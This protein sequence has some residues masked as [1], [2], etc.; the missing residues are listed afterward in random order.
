M[1]VP[2]RAAS[3]ASLFTGNFNRATSATAV[4]CYYGRI[5]MRRKLQWLSFLTSV[6]VLLL[7][8]RG[9]LSSQPSAPQVAPREELTRNGGF[10]ESGTSVPQSWFRDSART[11]KKGTV[12]QDHTRF[13]SG[14]ASLK[15]EPNKR[16]GGDFPLAIAQVI[17]AATW[18]GKKVEFSA[19]VAAEGGATAVLGMLNFVRQQPSNLITV[20]QA[21][22]VAGWVRQSQIYEVP[23]DPSVQ[24]VITCFVTGTSGSAWFDDVSVVPYGEGGGRGPA[25]GAANAT[26]APV[27]NSS[28]ALKASVEVDVGSVIRQIP[29]TLYG[30]NAEWIWNGNLLWLEESRRAHPEVERLTQELG[31]SLIRYPGGH[32][33]DFYHWRDGVGPFE[34]RPEALHEKGRNDRSRPNFGTDEALEFAQHVN[35]ELLITVNAGSGSAQEAADWVAHV[36]GK[37]ERVRYWEVGNELYLN[38]GS[39]MS[40]SITVNPMRYAERFREFAQAMQ[41][42]DPR[43]KLLAIGGENQGRY[44]NVNYADWNR[45]VLEKAGDQIDFLAVHNAYAPVLLSGDDKDL[46]TVYAAML[47]APVLI[48]RNLETIEQQIARYAPTRA[49]RIGLAVT[50]WGPLFQ[51]DFRGRYVDHPKTLG[52]A[53]FVAST[54]KAFIESPKMEI[55]NFFLLNDVSVLG[56]IGSRDGRVPPVP[57]WAP[58][59]RYFAFQL[60]TRHFGEQLV[61]SKAVGPTYDSKAVGQI[62]AVK[63]VPYLDIVSSLSSDGR[64]LYIM[65]INKHFDSA[66]DAEIVLRG[67]QPALG[68]TAWTLTGTGIDAHTGT[69]ALQGLLRGKGMEDSQNPRFSK[70]GA[71]EV[72]LSS[73]GVAGIKAQF[74][75]RFPP[76]S[77]TSLVLSRAK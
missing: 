54:L 47:A 18:A 64:K 7:V 28:G 46:R 59:A 35:G 11:G 60:F 52:S 36:N 70:G 55:A 65:A 42:V 21:S 50:E 14:N 26:Q 43:I 62:E 49:A 71:G 67:F 76:H 41:T 34:A 48:K 5:P 19:Y 2:F 53:L 27:S 69:T 13:H 10:E 39:A 22:G 38:E 25:E 15:L 16:N 68:G 56:F 75:Y 73:S 77:V 66:I 4:I 58:T 74:S 6:I 12:L 45:T 31:V 61:G 24:L 33:S 29:R 32:Y 40:K 37:S 3:K 1:G 57:D 72:I 9:L 30:A 44:A 8:G 17:P 23:D 63:D 20:T 51:F